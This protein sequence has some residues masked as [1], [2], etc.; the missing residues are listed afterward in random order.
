MKRLPL[1][2]TVTTKHP[3]IGIREYIKPIK[4]KWRLLQQASSGDHLCMA[5]SACR[6]EDTS[7][8]VSC[9]KAGIGNTLCKHHGRSWF[10]K[11]WRHYHLSSC[12]WHTSW[13]ELGI[14]C[15]S[16]GRLF[17]RAG[18]IANCEYWL[19]FFSKISAH[20]MGK[21]DRFLWKSKFCW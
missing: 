10:R 6:G 9:S 16:Q 11:I 15:H 14:I 2:L 7:F 21:G 12:H 20:K 8:C 4:S 1:R 3:A 17:R 13:K 18:S 5:C 19:F